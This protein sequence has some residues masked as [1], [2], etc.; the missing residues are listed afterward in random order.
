MF[1]FKLKE[2]LTSED[3]ESLRLFVE[4]RRCGDPREGES[5]CCQKG[6]GFQE[7]DVNL[8]PRESRKASTLLTVDLPL[9]SN[10]LQLDSLCLYCT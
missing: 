3:S 7:G 10:V 5:F 6:G 9:C 8:K 4:S 2:D 1:R